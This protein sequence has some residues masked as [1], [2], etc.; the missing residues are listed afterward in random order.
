MPEII[1]ISGERFGCLVA[2]EEVGRDS[3][4]SALWSY[5]CDCGA[6]GEKAGWR[7]R[8]KKTWKFCE[9]CVPKGPRGGVWR[10]RE[11]R[12][13]EAMKARCYNKRQW[14][15]AS[16]GG[17]GIRVCARWV[18][19]FAAF[20]ADM[21]QRPTPKHSIERKD[22]NGHYEP[23]NCYW[24]TD[25]EQRRNKTTTVYVEH[26]GVVVKLVDL[27]EQRGLSRGIVYGRLKMGW[28]LA[29][30]LTVPKRGYTPRKGV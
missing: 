10:T 27:V 8:A 20:L 13:W 25:T 7:L 28:S 1:D 5:R 15:Y 26:E 9:A 29:D 23:G 19:D 14:N 30:A 12:T 21:G 3:K 22:V 24:A 2:I 17:R 11:Y 6:E 16:Y 4:R 18:N